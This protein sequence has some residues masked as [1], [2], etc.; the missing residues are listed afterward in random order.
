MFAWL[1]RTVRQPKFSRR[2]RMN[3]VIYARKSTT[4]DGVAEEAKSV[5]RQVENATAFAAR[6]G[7]TI[8]DAH[9]YIDDGVGAAEFKRRP[10]FRSKRVRASVAECLSMSAVSIDAMAN[11]Q[12]PSTSR[13]QR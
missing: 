1:S 4:Q 10:G 12:M 6:K 13:S 2:K 3:A 5:V 7:W 11:A 9:S 8:S